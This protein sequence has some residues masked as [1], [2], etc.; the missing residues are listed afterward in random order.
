[1]KVLSD[2]TEVIS[3]GLWGEGVIGFKSGLGFRVD[4]IDIVE[5]GCSDEGRVALSVWLGFWEAL[6]DC[7]YWGV[8]DL[9][10]RLLLGFNFE[11]PVNRFLG[12]DGV[13]RFGERLVVRLVEQGGDLG[14]VVR[15]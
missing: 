14:F 12:G 7:E 9:P 8:G 5:V 15:L 10:S 3:S 4:F 6:E 1:M 11:Y 2:L 13:I